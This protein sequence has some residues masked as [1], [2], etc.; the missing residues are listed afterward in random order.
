MPIFAFIHTTIF[1]HWSY[2]HRW[3]SRILFFPLLCKHKLQRSG[4]DMQD[5]ICNIRKQTHY[6]NRNNLGRLK[7][8]LLLIRANNV[9]WFDSVWRKLF[10]I[11]PCWGW[12]GFDGGS[13]HQYWQFHFYSGAQKNRSRLS[14]ILVIKFGLEVSRQGERGGGKT[15]VQQDISGT[16]E[17]IYWFPHYKGEL[18]HCLTKFQCFMTSVEIPLGTDLSSHTPSSACWHLNAIL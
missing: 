5:K 17:R 6:P 10:E 9:I 1:C 15:I 16:N 13:V 2:R 4:G 18:P 3:F 12:I 11:H 14:T 7:Y 8:F